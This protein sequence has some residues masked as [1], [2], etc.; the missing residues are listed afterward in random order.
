MPSLEGIRLKLK[1]MYI[2]STAKKRRKLLKHTDFTIISN[3][4]WGGFVYQSYGIPYNSPTIGL[5]FMA[6]DYI[7]FVSDIRDYINAE[8]QFIPP[9][10]SR[11][12]NTIKSD[13][14]FGRYPIGRLNDIEILFLHYDSEEEAY[15]KWKRR[16]EKN[17]WNKLLIKFNDQNGCTKEMLN[18]FCDL[19][20]KNKICFTS[21]DHTELQDIYHIKSA[22]K[23]SSILASYEPVGN[24]KWININDIITSCIY[25]YFYKLTTSM[26]YLAL[27]KED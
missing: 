19:P 7:K 25:E 8:L 20:Y 23:H 21:K 2:H 4:C 10:S 18:I 22:N 6:E 11:Y 17:N 5:F 12:Y 9:E 15:S 13:K 1:R 3:N 16:C 27:K 14:R 24:S 26:K